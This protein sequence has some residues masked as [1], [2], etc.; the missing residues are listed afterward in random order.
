MIVHSFPKNATQEVRA[1]L[2]E[3]RGCRVASLWVF[4]AS[5][6]GIVPTRHGLSLSVESLPQLEAAVQKLRAAAIDPA[7][8]EVNGVE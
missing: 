1:A 7:S 8:F 5:R 6:D 2:G 3:Y 4:A